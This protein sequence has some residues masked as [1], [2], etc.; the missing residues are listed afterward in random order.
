MNF[1][2]LQS[3]A[4]FQNGKCLQ[5]FNNWHS[6]QYRDHRPGS[7]LNSAR[8][9]QFLTEQHIQNYYLN[10]IWI[11]QCAPHAM[12][13]VG[14]SYIVQYVWYKTFVSLHRPQESM[15]PALKRTA[16]LIGTREDS[17]TGEQLPQTAGRGQGQF[18]NHWASQAAKTSKEQGT[19]V[20]RQVLFTKHICTYS[21][22][23]V[24]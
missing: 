12:L 15:Q 3:K 18:Q 20:P 22:P 9:W 5:L 8:S 11:C 10:Y 2:L 1:L 7:F 16:Y 13:H 23:C 14:R 24:Q 4:V 21:P 6:T 17:N 19:G